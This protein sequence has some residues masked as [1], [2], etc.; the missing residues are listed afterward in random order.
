MKR[1][2]VSGKKHHDITSLNK[3][4]TLFF[5]ANVPVHFRTKQRAKYT[6]PQ[7][8]AVCIVARKC[9]RQQPVP[10]SPSVG[11]I[12]R[13]GGR[14]TGSGREQRWAG[15][16]VIIVLK[17]QFCP[18]EKRNRFLFQNVKCQN[19]S[20]CQ[21]VQQLLTVLVHS[22]LCSSAIVHVR[23]VSKNLSECKSLC[24]GVQILNT[25]K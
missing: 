6:S 8:K 14:R 2:L 24:V 12:E 15:E 23:C 13:A 11:T 9:L 3:R 22:V 1:I 4:I 10:C 19:S 17:T 18:L 5:D 16:P 25:G 21:Y 7:P 20:K